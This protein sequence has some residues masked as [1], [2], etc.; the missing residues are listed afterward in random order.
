MKGWQDNLLWL[1][2]RRDPKKEHN[3]YRPHHSHA[4]HI[5]LRA[6]RGKRCQPAELSQ[7]Y[8][9][10]KALVDH[11]SLVLMQ[12]L[13]F[14]EICNVKLFQNNCHKRYFNPLKSLFCA[15]I[16]Q[17]DKEWLRPSNWDCETLISWNTDM[18]FFHCIQF[19]LFLL[20][21]YGIEIVSQ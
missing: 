16:Y 9:K 10:S 3:N 15:E 6:G 20:F 7:T 18:Y 17:Y 4:A 21:K 1:M 13:K 19:I 5:Q 14:S 2:G 12:L 11:T 8:Q